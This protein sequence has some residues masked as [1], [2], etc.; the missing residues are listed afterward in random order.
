MKKRRKK[1]IEIAISKYIKHLF[2]LDVDII[3][4]HHFWGCY[5][6]RVDMNDKF[7]I[8]IAE[9]AL[10]D[11]KTYIWHEMGHI[12]MGCYNSKRCVEEE[13]IAESWALF[14]MC[15]RGYTKLYKKAIHRIRSW[16]TDFTYSDMNQ[17][18]YKKAAKI[19]LT[20]FGELDQYNH[21]SNKSNS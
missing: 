16:D 12:K 17:R 18:P 5:A 14:E 4:R 8:E 15:K 1:R 19:I 10:Q 9:D 7:V 6:A 20:L 3:V 21:D 11:W 13:V 2:G